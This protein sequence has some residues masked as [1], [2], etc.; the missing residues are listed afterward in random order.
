MLFRSVNVTTTTKGRIR[1]RVRL[2]KPNYTV[3]VDP[4]LN[5]SPGI[6]GRTYQAPGT[7]EYINET[8]QK[9]QAVATIL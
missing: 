4:Q 7:G 1:A 8:A 6:V 3:Y 5:I 9:R 2:A